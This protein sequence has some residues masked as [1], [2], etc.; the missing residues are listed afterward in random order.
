MACLLHQQ[1]EWR[2]EIEQLSWKPRAFL[3]KGFLSDEECEHIKTM[4]SLCW[5]LHTAAALQQ[6]PRLASYGVRACCSQVARA[7]C[8]WLVGCAAD[9]QIA[10]ASVVRASQQQQQQNSELP[11]APTVPSLG[12]S[13]SS[14]HP[15]P[16]EAT[17]TPCITDALSFLKTHILPTSTHSGH[18]LGHPLS[19]PSTLT[20]QHTP[21]HTHTP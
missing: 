7:L 3:V 15:P 8:S 17:H 12:H 5:G 21:P 14:G 6:H 1:E 11:S 19:S 2:G 16:E 9:I 4:V 20:P 18:P 13:R 10:V